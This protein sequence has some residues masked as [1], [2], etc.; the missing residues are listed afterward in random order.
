MP[1]IP[2]INKDITLLSK[3]IND[4]INQPKHQRNLVL[5]I[6][7]IALLLDNML[8]MVIVPIIPELI[9]NQRGES[10]KTTMIASNSMLNSNTGLVTTLMPVYGSPLSS[11]R[12][13]VTKKS[14]EEVN[15]DEDDDDDNE[16]NDNNN[17][18]DEDEAKSQT[19]STSTKSSRLA[20]RVRISRAARRVRT[21]PKEQT[22]TFTTFVVTPPPDSTRRNEKLTST[23]MSSEDS[24]DIAV[25]FLFASK[26]MV[27]L[28]INPFSG[29]FIDR[30]GYDIPMC[31]GLS[32]IFL[33]TMTFSFGSSYSLLFLARSLQGVGSAFADTSGLA[34]IADRFTEEGERSKALGIALA[35]ISFGSLVAPPFGGFLHE[36]MGRSVP[37][38]LL[39]FLALFDG[40]M[41]FFVMRPHRTA[42]SFQQESYKPKGTP[43]W[44]LFKDPYIAVCSGALVMANVSLAFLEP[45]IAIWMRETMNATESQIGFVWLPGFIPHL[46]G[47]LFTVW[48]AKR[49]PQHQWLL[50][51]SG[52]A[53]EGASCF[54]IP[55]CSSYLSIMLPISG[56]CF[57]IALVDTAIL[58]TLGYLVDVR[59]TS[60]YGSI[61]A[62][63]DISYSLA[64]AFGP[65]LASNIVYGLGFTALNI[66]ICF[67]NLLY[68]PVIYFL[69]YF[70]EFK[71]LEV[72]ELSA[73]SSK[74]NANSG[75]GFKQFVND[76]DSAGDQQSQ[77]VFNSDY[78]SLDT[79][80][81]VNFNTGTKQ[82]PDSAVFQNMQKYPK[83]TSKN[84]Y[85]DTHNLIDN[86]DQDDDY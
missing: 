3:D 29:A 61:Y 58:P 65:I 82:R 83:K 11:F 13:N 18:L 62:I 56:I 9:M 41:L 16:E 54:I 68:A 51:A 75:A 52:L 49:F 72:N 44:R 15:K 40:F 73:I 42:M 59:H 17:E 79:S 10:S 57:G 4:R 23:A 30:I 34:M 67:S 28:L 25:G 37:F 80:P 43:I 74:M 76:Y 85:K 39:A 35:F 26:A 77:A 69:R 63:A 45:T 7:C 47:V 71:P 66:G 50:A 19:S 22:Q 36:Y 8:Y 6:V 20:G 86:M 2:G 33:S 78:T 1:V 38:I 31:I 12:P 81:G 24:D 70:Y 55:F 5:I 60:V 32:I 21:K 27:Q 64:Y 53:L 14:E 84:P 48:M 46:C